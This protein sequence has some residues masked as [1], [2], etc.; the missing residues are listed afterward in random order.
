MTCIIK[1]S[2]LDLLKYSKI[3]SNNHQ[4]LEKCQILNNKVKL[5]NRKK[6]PELNIEQ[7]IENLYKVEM[8]KFERSEKKYKNSRLR[9]GSR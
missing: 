2:A 5:S 4:I 7:L 8:Q 9:L 6:Q 1:Y 3:H